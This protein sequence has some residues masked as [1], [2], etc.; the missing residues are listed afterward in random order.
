MSTYRQL[1]EGQSTLAC[2]LQGMEGMRTSVEL[3]SE[4]VVEGVIESVDA[5]MKYD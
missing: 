5:A 3:R 1:K 4:D 2:L